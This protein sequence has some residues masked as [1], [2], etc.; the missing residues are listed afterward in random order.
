MVFF[1]DEAIFHEDISVVNSCVIPDEGNNCTHPVEED[2]IAGSSPDSKLN[3]IIG[4][5]LKLVDIGLPEDDDGNECNDEK[6][7]H[8]AIHPCSSRAQWLILISI[9]SNLFLDILFQFM[10]ILD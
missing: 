2:E 7:K 8:E 9:D 4:C 3:A 1:H 5:I 10:M 6:G